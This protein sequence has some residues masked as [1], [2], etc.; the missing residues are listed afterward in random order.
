MRLVSTHRSPLA[1]ILV[2]VVMTATLAVL[3]ADGVHVPSAGSMDGVCAVMTHSSALGS[4]ASA[5][6]WLLVVS[7]FLTAIVGL[8]TVL[9][10][11][12]VLR[13]AGRHTVSLGRCADPLNMRLRL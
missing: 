1:T 7:M 9:N 12:L 13:L 4:A 11:T 6:S 8:A 5:D 2:I 3:C 10:T